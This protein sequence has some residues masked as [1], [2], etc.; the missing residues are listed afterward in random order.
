MLNTKHVFGKAACKV[1]FRFVAT[2]SYLLAKSEPMFEP[3][4]DDIVQPTV[5]FNKSYLPVSVTLK[6]TLTPLYKQVHSETD[7]IIRK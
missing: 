4:K 1:P 7:K 6:Q 5:S 2:V 3:R